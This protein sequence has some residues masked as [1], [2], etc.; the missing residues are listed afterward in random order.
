MLCIFHIITSSC[1]I[2][3]QVKKTAENVGE[4]V[5][6]LPDA[7]QVLRCTVLVSFLSLEI[8][9]TFPFCDIAF[10]WYPETGWFMDESFEGGS[11][12]TS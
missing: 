1:D 9:L 7:N 4:A 8:L 11:S 12:Q 10:L 2:H 5:R 6:E 3:T